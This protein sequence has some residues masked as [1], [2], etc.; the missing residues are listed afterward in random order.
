MNIYQNIEHFYAKGDLFRI[1][2]KITEDDDEAEEIMHQTI[3]RLLA[4]AGK[5]ADRNFLGLYKTSLYRLHINNIR[6]NKIRRNIL[7][8]RVKD[9]VHQDVESEAHYKILFK[10]LLGSLN[11]KSKKILNLKL[12]E[13]QTK[14]I[15]SELGCSEGSINFQYH[16]IKRKVLD[17]GR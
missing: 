15:A 7:I 10:D 4:N 11:I 9:V 3:E 8:D 2:L 12:E 1:A 17:Y 13:Y 6:N 14:E 5:Y 16:T